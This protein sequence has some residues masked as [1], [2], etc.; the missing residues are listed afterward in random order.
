LAESFN[1]ADD[2]IAKENALDRY[3]SEGEDDEDNE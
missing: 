3:A 1:K 2:D